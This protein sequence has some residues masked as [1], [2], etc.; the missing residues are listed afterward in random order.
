VAGESEKLKGFL[1]DAIRWTF[2]PS[3]A[4]AA[5]LLA[6]GEPILALFGPGFAD[7][8]PLIC[9]MAIGLLARSAVGPAERLLNMI[10]EGKICAAIYGGAFAVNLI[11]CVTLIPRFG[12]YGAAIATATAVVVE[13]VSLFVMTKRRLGLHVFI[14]GGPAGP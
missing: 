14:W 1:K 8:Y 2:W 3:L 9:I 4:L 6:L 7:G 13:S 5:L 12:L 10:G 11:L